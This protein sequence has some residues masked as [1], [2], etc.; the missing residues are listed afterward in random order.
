MT[1]NLTI[2]RSLCVSYAENEVR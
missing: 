1:A 2:K